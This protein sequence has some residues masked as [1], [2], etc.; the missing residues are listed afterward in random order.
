MLRKVVDARKKKILILNQEI[1]SQIRSLNSDRK[2]RET[3]NE[4][5]HGLMLSQQRSSDKQKHLIVNAEALIGAPV[6]WVV[7]ESHLIDNYS[8]M[9]KKIDYLSQ[10]LKRMGP[11]NLAAIEEVSHLNERHAYLLSQQQDLSSAI[12]TLNQAIH[13]IDHETKQK[14]KEAY[15]HVS[16]NV[17]HLF[18]LLFKGGKAKLNLI[19]SD[20]LEAGIGIEAQPAGKKCA[21]I[22]L[23]SGG[24]KTLTAIALLF[25]LFSYRP[26]PFCLLDEVDAALDDQNIQKFSSLLKQMAK[27][28][29]I[30]VVSHHK[31]TLSVANQLIGIT[32]RE[33]GVSRQVSVNIDQALRMAEKST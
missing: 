33:A 27:R 20:I 10:H 13:D 2:L 22:H 7:N 15:A 24:E 25:A 26:A 23:L 12:S 3:C 6:D 4:T 29:Q 1:E 31:H 19:G 21:S 14:F 18:S 8:S 17:S 32:M 11:V 9:L 16:Q 28:L 5:R 30:M